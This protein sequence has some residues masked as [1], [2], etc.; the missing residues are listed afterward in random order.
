MLLHLL[1]LLVFLEADSALP[2]PILSESS[3][4][5]IQNFSKVLDPANEF[6]CNPKKIVVKLKVSILLTKVLNSAH[7]WRPTAWTDGCLET[8]V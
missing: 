3:Y 2:T 4:V 6:W 7:H 5:S 1:Q 8:G